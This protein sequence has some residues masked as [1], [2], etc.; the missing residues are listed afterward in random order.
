[1]KYAILIED[2]RYGLL[3]RYSIPRWLHK[4]YVSSSSL[5]LFPDGKIAVAHTATCQ[6]CDRG[7]TE[8]TKDT[9]NVCLDLDINHGIGYPGKICIDCV[10]YLRVRSGGKAPN[11]IQK[12]LDAGHKPRMLQYY[13]DNVL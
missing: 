7:F 13:L 10:Y 8:A 2:K 4:S 11:S 12:V 9:P 3:S 6:L 1:M 5:I